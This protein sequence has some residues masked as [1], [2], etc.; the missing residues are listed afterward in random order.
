MQTRSKRIALERQVI[1]SP[2]E[3]VEVVE[4]VETCAICCESLTSTEP[5]KTVHEDPHHQWKHCFHE[6]C[7]DEWS[8]ACIA[9]QKAPSCPLCPSIHIPKHSFPLKNFRNIALNYFEGVRNSYRVTPYFGFIIC[10]E[11]ECVMKV[12]D[13]DIFEKPISYETTLRTIKKI[14]SKMGPKIYGELGGVFSS[15]NSKHNRSLL[16]WANWTYPTLEVVHTCYTIPPRRISY[17][18]LDIVHNDDLTLRD[19]YIEY[20]TQ[21]ERMKCDKETHPEI[22][23]QMHDISTKKDLKWNAGYY[24]YDAMTDYPYFEEGYYDRGYMN[25]ENPEMS[26]NNCAFKYNNKATNNPL[27]WI[28]IHTKYV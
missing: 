22:L 21:L 17:G 2:V 1:N 25:P 4:V 23:E 26:K 8:F 5:I 12:T 6:K 20:H 10:I 7:I 3:V 24:A 28:A 14:V 13:I 19:M 27:A 18:D 16:N 9:K 11:G 15:V